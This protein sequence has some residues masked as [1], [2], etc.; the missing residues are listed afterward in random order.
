MHRSRSSRA[1]VP[2]VL[3]LLLALRDAAKHHPIVWQAPEA[4]QASRYQRY[5]AP[6]LT[7]LSVILIAPPLAASA[8]QIARSHTLRRVHRPHSQRNSPR[9]AALAHTAIVGGS[10]AETNSFP[11]LAFIVDKRPEGIERC[12]ATVVAPDLVLTAGHCAEDVETGIA[13]EPSGYSVVTGNVDWTSPD[14]Q[15][16]AVSR[17]IVYPGFARN[18][19]D[20]DAALL[21]LATP[22]SAPALVLAE[23][24]S[25]SSILQGGTGAT[26]AGWGE[27]SPAEEALPE[28]LQWA[29]TVVQ[30]PEWCESEVKLFY[31]GSELC[32]IDPP[33]YSTGACSGDS[34]GPLIA[35]TPSGT[36]VEIGVTVRASADCSTSHPT[37]FTR[38]DLIASWVHEWAEAV[39]PAPPP[40][41]TPQPAA[42]RP[43]AA[44]SP[45]PAVVEKPSPAAPPWTPPNE[46]G[47]YVTPQSRNRRIAARVSGD[48][49][50]LVLI[51]IKV[52]VNCKRGY[53]Y[54]LEGS[55]LSYQENE[56]IENH[57]VRTTL[58]TEASPYVKAGHVGLYLR[59]N[60]SGS[61]EGR[62]RVRIVAKSKRV[63]LCYART[64]SFTAHRSG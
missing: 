51:D 27:T 24:P 60:G 9:R 4:R 55:W 59:F 1:A 49:K 56:V 20:R 50:H 43:A 28:G 3:A 16:S 37:V 21:V 5:S 8:H 64:I 44:P 10:P 22:T 46:P 45:T 31:A 58:E 25:D 36:P 11:W 26:I 47:L 18:V 7:A 41:P 62:L 19:D 33:S 14:R 39:K 42:P 32:A 35:E 52:N 40:P 6:L 57:V 17:V 34:G 13:N 63:G 15:V 30:E 48:G 12:S 53:Y 29:E 2:P 54:P 23:W 61:V 38:A